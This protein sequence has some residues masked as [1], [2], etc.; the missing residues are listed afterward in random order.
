MNYWL[1]IYRFAVAIIVVLCLIGVMF[2][3]LPK[4]Y[5]ISKLQQTK[6]QLENENKQRETDT[7]ELRIKQERF[8]SDPAF[9][10]RTAREVGMVKPHEVVFRFSNA[11]ENA[12]GP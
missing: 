5:R 12:T 6:T 11:T 4:C 8:T 7:R 3:F 2:M 10:Q 9:V 1:I